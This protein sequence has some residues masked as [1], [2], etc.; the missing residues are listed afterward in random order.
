[1][2]FKQLHVYSFISVVCGSQPIQLLR[3]KRWWWW[4]I[5]ALVLK[6][7]NVGLCIIIL[8][9]SEAASSLPPVWG[10]LIRRLKNSWK[11]PVLLKYLQLKYK[12]LH[13]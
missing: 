9:M 5:Y 8:L 10:C 2:G 7:L 4:L 1:M 11:T 6:F 3:L 12:V 13:K